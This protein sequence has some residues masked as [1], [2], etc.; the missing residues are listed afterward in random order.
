MTPG[1]KSTGM[2]AFFKFLQNIPNSKLI[3]VGGAGYKVLS[4]IDGE[5]D[6]YIEPRIGTYR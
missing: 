5:A 1:F 2:E 3:S 6:Y 4:I